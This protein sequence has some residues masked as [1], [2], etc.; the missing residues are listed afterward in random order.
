[1]SRKGISIIF[2][3]S[4]ISISFRKVNTSVLDYSRKKNKK[5]RGR[6]G[7]EDMELPVLLKK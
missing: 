2:I 7:I 5:E 4:I 3:S 6:R 1:M